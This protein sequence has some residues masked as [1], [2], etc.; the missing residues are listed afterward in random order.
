MLAAIRSAST[1]ARAGLYMVLAMAAFVTNDTCVKVFASQLPVGEIVA[2]RGAMATLFIA[3]I[4]RWHGVLNHFPRVFGR[5]VLFRAMLDLVG[6]LL[7]ITALMHMP[8]A[9]ITSIMQAVPLV[10]IA[11]AALFL[12][13]PVGYRRSLAVAV[14]LIGVMF[15]VKPSPSQFSLFEGLALVIVVVLAVRDIVTRRIAARVPSQIV[16]LANALFVTAGGLALGIYEGFVPMTLAQFAG[17]GAAA[18]FLGIG[19]VFMVATLR[20][21][22]IA[23]TAPY[24]YA[25]V[26]FSIVSGVLVFGEYP[27]GLAF[28]GMGLVAGSGIYALHREMTLDREAI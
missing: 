24:R 8:I 9:N 27:D 12:G 13:E 11:F 1:P 20:I 16:A 5:K 4:C 21:G 14:G 2:V 7:F 15:I 17:L 22:E 25:I 18:F 28:I 3:A 23:A 10:V 26:L 19:Y 6:T